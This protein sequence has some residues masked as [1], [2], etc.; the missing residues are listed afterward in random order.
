MRAAVRLVVIVIFLASGIGHGQAKG[1]AP[2]VTKENTFYVPFTVAEQRDSANSRIHAQLFV[3]GDH[4]SSWQFYQQQPAAPGRFSFRAGTDGEFWFAVRMA[5]K[6]QPPVL[7][8]AEPELKVVVDRQQ[9]AVEF[10]ADPLTAGTT[11]IR[12]TASD[13]Q[14]DPSSFSLQYRTS[15][16]TDWQDVPKDAVEIESETTRLVGETQLNGANLT[17]PFVIRAQIQDRAGNV[18]SVERSMKESNL[19]LVTSP[20]AVAQDRSPALDTDQRTL[21]PESPVPP[22]GASPRNSTAWNSRPVT[23][24]PVV[25]HDSPN[26]WQPSIEPGSPSRTPSGQPLATR[27]MSGTPQP[28]VTSQFVADQQP[29]TGQQRVSRSRK[30]Q[31]DYDVE[32]GAAGGLHRIEVW[33]TRDGGQTWRHHGDDP[34]KASPYLVEVAEDGVYGF[35][36]TVQAK[37]GFAVQPPRNG[38]PPDIWVHVDATPPQARI[39][40]ARYGQAAQLGQLEITWEVQDRDLTDRP[41]ALL[42]GENRN[43]P[44]RKLAENL[45]NTGAYTWPLDDRVPRLFYLRLEATD[46]AGNVAANTLREPIR[47][48][49]LAPQGR[50][51]DVRPAS[52]RGFGIGRNGFFK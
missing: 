36:L 31:L 25:H 40:S 44:W 10:Q 19:T 28:R 2:I 26:G 29:A 12:V 21:P 13:P 32:T 8:T 3:S 43:G 41:I 45:P 42:F 24:P 7:M 22:P 35:R 4:G 46:R 50:I 23:H 38:D 33:F 30:F 16:Q 39:T 18:A 52:R 49:G 48:D 14:L 15:D 34:D 37:E 20:A 6:G 51:R 27:G 47:S 9:P 11:M 17:Q 5:Q 1:D